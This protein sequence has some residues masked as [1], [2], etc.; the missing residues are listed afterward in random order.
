MGKVRTQRPYYGKLSQRLDA[1]AAKAA[2]A[3]D[4]KSAKMLREKSRELVEKRR[5]GQ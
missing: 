4:L 2:R 1:A 3:G 5:K